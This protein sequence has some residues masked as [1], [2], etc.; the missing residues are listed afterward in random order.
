MVKIGL[1]DTSW[2]KMNL[3]WIK[4]HTVVVDG[5]FLVKGCFSPMEAPTH[6]N[7]TPAQP[8]RNSFDILMATDYFQVTFKTI[9]ISPEDI[10]CG[11]EIPDDGVS[12][13]IPCSVL[14]S[15]NL[16]SWEAQS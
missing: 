14:S 1:V 11:P 12:S 5:S 16:H 6:F 8:K 3:H 10:F 4:W 15:T 7:I 2:D 9:Q 13:A